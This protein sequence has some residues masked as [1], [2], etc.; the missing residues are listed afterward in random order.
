MG[1]SR[2][3]I[4]VIGGAGYTAVVLSL[5]RLLGKIENALRLGA[6]LDKPLSQSVLVFADSRLSEAST[7]ESKLFTVVANANGEC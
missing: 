5:L 4:D 3:W 1:A 7:S 2:L 6:F